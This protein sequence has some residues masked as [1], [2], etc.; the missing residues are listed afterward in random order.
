MLKNDKWFTAYN[1]GF[2]AGAKQQRETD[3]E[4]L[5]NLLQDLESI[6]GIGE[7]KAWNIRE[8]FLNKFGLGENE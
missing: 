8:H 5:F 2:V 4:N 6:P 3:I 7:K 1:A